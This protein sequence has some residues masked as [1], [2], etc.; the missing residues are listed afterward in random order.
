MYWI[1]SYSVEWLGYNK[2]ETMWKEIGGGLIQGT[3]TALT[4]R[5]LKPHEK[6]E[7]SRCPGRG[8]NSAPRVTAKNSTGETRFT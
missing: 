6:T 4:W 3:I 8:S 1:T 5:G 7:G 2:L